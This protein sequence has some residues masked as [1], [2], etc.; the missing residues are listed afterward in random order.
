MEN[1]GTYFL[2]RKNWPKLKNS[3]LQWQNKLCYLCVPQITENL[4]DINPCCLVFGPWTSSTGTSWRL[5]AR[6]TESESVLYH[7]P[8]LKFERT[9]LQNILHLW[10][11]R[12]R[13]GDTMVLL[14]STWVDENV[15]VCVCV[16]YLGSIQCSWCGLIQTVLL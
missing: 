1:K 8:T 15:C 14:H 12:K 16:H 10:L 11:L 4:A 2:K 7:D 3:A 9:K 13:H 5:S 6:R